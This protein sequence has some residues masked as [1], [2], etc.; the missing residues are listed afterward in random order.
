MASQVNLVILR[1]DET[2][3]V[4]YTRRA[5]KG[6]K[7]NNKLSLKKYSAK[8]KKPIVFKEVKKLS[9]LKKNK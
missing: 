6:D 9:K 3:E 7:A 8:L 4:Y 1:N 2:G 5:K